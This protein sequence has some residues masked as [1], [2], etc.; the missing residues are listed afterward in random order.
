MDQANGLLLWKLIKGY[1]FQD[2]EREHRDRIRSIKQQFDDS[3]KKAD[4][5]FVNKAWNSASNSIYRLEVLNMSIFQDKQLIEA[6][7]LF[8]GQ[9]SD[10]YLVRKEIPK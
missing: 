8:S 9:C 2:L 6:G 3:V 1:I 4:L 10:L 7:E 5:Y